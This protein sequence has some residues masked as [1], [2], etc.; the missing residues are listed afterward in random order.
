METWSKM[1][2]MVALA[3]GRSAGAL[4]DTKT[5]AAGVPPGCL[6]SG[7][8]RPPRELNSASPGS[9]WSPAGRFADLGRDPRASRVD[10]VV[11]VLV[12]ERAS[13]V[14]KG[15][16]KS[17]RASSANS[18]SAPWPG[19]AGPRSRRLPPCR[20]TS[21]CGEGATSARAN[22]PPRSPRG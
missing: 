18:S 17:A 12:V 3:L 11:T 10:D 7:G 9:L 6:R 5:A 20:A 15:T 14:A 4:G 13:A 2:L 8:H 22:C 16:T 21:N 1:T 19:S